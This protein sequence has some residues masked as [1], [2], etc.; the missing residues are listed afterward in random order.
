MQI[1]TAMYPS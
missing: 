1:H